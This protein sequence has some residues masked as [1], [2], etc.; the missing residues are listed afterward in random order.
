MLLRM[1]SLSGL[2]LSRVQAI[3][4]ANAQTSKITTPIVRVPDS[5]P[6]YMKKILDSLKLPGGALVPMIETKEMAEKVVQATRYPRQLVDSDDPSIIQGGGGG[7]RGCAVPFIRASSYG[8]NTN[9]M[10]QQCQ[11]D[12]LVMVQVETRKGV[13]AIPDIAKVDGIDGIFLGP[14]DLSASIGKVG[15][16]DDIEVKELLR[17]AER[18][19]VDSASDCFLGG[20]Q[21]PGRDL[22]KMF[23][24]DVVTV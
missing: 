22:H 12:L 2:P 14:Y 24:E 1:I 21:S 3:N 7:I 23:H 10:K 8:V 19:V 17:K 13:D 6:T 18:A 11:E 20:F 9:Y 4:A 15:Q 5:D 16:F